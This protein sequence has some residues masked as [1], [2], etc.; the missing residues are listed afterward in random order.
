MAINLQGIR[1]AVMNKEQLMNEPS[2]LS[3]SCHFTTGRV[4][5]HWSHDQKIQ[6]R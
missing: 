4:V 1:T 5:I 3:E 6:N 2:S